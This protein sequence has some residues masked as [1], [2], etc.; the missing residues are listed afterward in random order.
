MTTNS[1]FMK[2]PMMVEARD[3]LRSEH[4][5]DDCEQ[6]DEYWQLYLDSLLAKLDPCPRKKHHK[7]LLS[8]IV[9][10][11]SCIP[12]S[13][14]SEIDGVRSVLQEFVSVKHYLPSDLRDINVYQSIDDL[15]TH[16]Y[17]ARLNGGRASKAILDSLNFQDVY[18]TASVHYEG[19]GLI[20]FKPRSIEEAIVLS[21]GARWSFDDRG[22][23]LY[24]ELRRVGTPLIWYTDVGKLLSV[25]PYEYPF[26]GS[27]LDQEGDSLILNEFSSLYPGLDLT[28]SGLITAILAADSECP[29]YAD[30]G[31]EPKLLAIHL[32]PFLLEKPEIREYVEEIIA[33]SDLHA[34]F[35]ASSMLEVHRSIE[36]LQCN[37]L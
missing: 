4:G 26:S 34:A 14:L 16:L 6:G 27:V 9:D 17:L 3:L 31:V 2:E 11:D 13:M 28:D 10:E 29:F 1:R 5:Q 18:Q 20:I 7:W 23:G 19:Q 30:W 15:K 33:G 36:G 21:D 8:R 32:N 37:D 35:W 22:D 24:R 25:I 12:L